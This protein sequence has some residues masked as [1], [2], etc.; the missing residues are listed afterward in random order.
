[1]PTIAKSHARSAGLFAILLVSAALC[2]PNLLALDV[3]RAPAAAP[4]LAVSKTLTLT[5][6]GGRNPTVA[7]DQRSGAVYL[8]W[9]QEIPGETV[10]QGKKVDPV[11]QVLVARSDDGRRSFGPPVVVNSP[12]DHVVSYTV[13]PTQVA[14]GPKGEV[15]VL[16]EHND[17]DF[18]VP[19]NWKWGRGVLRLAR[20]EDGGRSFGPPV[21]V[22]GESVEGVRTTTEM[23][24]LFAAPNGDLYA[25][26]VDSREVFDYLFAHHEDPPDDAYP[27]YQLRVAR[28]TDGGRTFA[29]SVLV[30][31]PT[32]GCCGTKVA[33][34]ANGPLYATTR[35]QWKELKRS[36]DDVRDIF[37]STSRDHGVIWSKAVKVHDDRFKI[38]GCPDVTSGLAVDSRGRLHAAWY[39][40]TDRH[41]GIFYARSED[42]GKTF[43]NPLAL[44]ADDWVP[45]GDVKLALDAKDHVW[46]A[47][48]DRRGEQD[49]IQLARIFPEGTLALSQAWPG[50]A[51]D[52]AVQGETAIVTWGTQ[53]AE[54][55][56][57]GGA[58]RWLMA[59]STQAR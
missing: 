11:L 32:C 35:A 50:T 24:N 8:A 19:G 40:G 12:Q 51:P 53:A 45:Y 17:R 6:K 39:T 22:G 59:R 57:R 33:Q 2:G 26:W 30:S 3:E 18:K 37:V 27:P 54:G 47:F 31:K 14:V 23:L 44:L 5:P 28:S 38:S 25:S 48:E 4:P 42:E 9:A 58:I 36:Y 29:K 10:K 34:G 20:S 15:Y 16:Y 21:E 55:E 1:M 56:E 43:S 7:A 46:V 52:V 49:L 41:P 13:S